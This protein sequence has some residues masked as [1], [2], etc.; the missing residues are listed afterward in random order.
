MT[1]NDLKRLAADLE[2]LG[3]SARAYSA[4]KGAGRHWRGPTLELSRHG[5]AFKFNL[6]GTYKTM[7][8]IE[9]DPSPVSTQ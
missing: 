7:T 9:I 5:A 1:F 2:S 3:I 8:E 6:D 4:G